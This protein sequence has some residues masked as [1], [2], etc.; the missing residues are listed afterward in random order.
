MGLEGDEM[1]R[2]TGPALGCDEARALLPLL[3]VDALEPDERADLDAHLAGCAACAAE[4]R[5]VSAA[6]SAVASLGPA[7]RA[8]PPAVWDRLVRELDVPA[9][10]ELAAVRAVSGIRVALDCAYCK[11]TIARSE[12]AFCA[13][14]LAPH[15]EECFRAHRRCSTYGCD[16]TRL[17]RPK[18]AS[19]EPATQAPRVAEPGRFRRFG[20]PLLVATL[21]GLVSAAAVVGATRP[22]TSAANLVAEVGERRAAELLVQANEELAKDPPNTTWGACRCLDTALAAL[23]PGPSELRARI[24]DRKIE[25]MLAWELGLASRPGI[26]SELA[27]IGSLAGA[28]RHR[29]EIELARAENRERL[30]QKEAR[31][32]KLLE[33]PEHGPGPRLQYP[34]HRAPSLTGAVI[35]GKVDLEWTP[36]PDDSFVRIVKVRVQRRDVGEEAWREVASL[37]GDKVAGGWLDQGSPTKPREYRIVETA[38]TDREDPIIAIAHGKAELADADLEKTSEVWRTPEHPEREWLEKARASVHAGGGLLA[39]PAYANALGL[40]PRDASIRLERAR[41]LLAADGGSDSS[42]RTALEDAQTVIDLDP[43]SPEGWLLRAEVELDR[44]SDLDGALRDA[45]EAVTASG[46][47]DVRAL[48]LRARV[49]EKRGDRAAQLAD[50]DRAVALAPSDVAVLGDRA[51]LRLAGGDLAGA[52]EDMSRLIE[53]APTSRFPR[54]ARAAARLGLG[55]ADGAL[56]DATRC[57]ELDATDSD[58]LCLRARARLAKKDAAGAVT[59]ASRAIELGAKADAL[60]IRAEASLA[61]GDLDGAGLDASAVLSGGGSGVAALTSTQGFEAT[62]LRGLARARKGYTGGARSDL[63]AFLEGPVGTAAQRAEAERALHGLG[64]GGK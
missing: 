4:S 27:A 13:S 25:A 52:A 51:D 1:S 37:E 38:E 59:D 33:S 53:L 42:Q 20:S 32:R 9:P 19:G 14:C 40:A 56:A 44:R 57:L 6:V 43:R 64:E 34:V 26:D 63:S 2:E 46:K 3:P 10:D 41:T 45:S 5:K 31:D 61:T 29:A 39:L 22:R 36:S 54:R 16:E 8:P 35:P 23:P 58:A 48:R 60:L 62:R 18:E 28:E 7:R 55:D 15:H 30:A 49:H 47:A 12:A 24:E 17:V 11:G 21:G 50:L